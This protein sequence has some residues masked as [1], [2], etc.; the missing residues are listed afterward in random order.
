MTKQVFITMVM[1][2]AL[3]ASAQSQKITVSKGQKLES[4]SVMKMNMTI[5]MMGQSMEN[6]FDTKTTSE[7]E[8]KDVT[9]KGFLLSNTIKRVVSKVTA[10]GNDIN[11]DSDKKE[12]MDGQM[13]E[14][15]KGKI[16]TPKELLVGKDGKIAE[17]IGEQKEDAAGMG[18]MLNIESMSKGQ[19]YP[20]LI[21]LPSGNVKP[22]D[23]WTDSSGTPETVKRVMFYTLKEIKGD[24]IIV[25][26]TG[27]MAKTGTIQQG[28]MEILMDIG[29]DM[30]GE[31]AYEKVS[32][33]LKTNTMDVDIKGTMEVMGQSAPITMKMAIVTTNKKL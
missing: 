33:W 9:E 24:D 7:I 6:I 15:Y 26:F 20:L 1:A 25:S 14:A 21:Q 2:I 11:F 10:M 3:F 31:S 12:D 27:R 17:V 32:G 30:T 13:G 4:G 22:G 29:G 28:G 23:T 18:S 8:V 19:S 5:D 16:N